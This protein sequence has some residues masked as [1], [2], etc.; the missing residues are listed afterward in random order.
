PLGLSGLFGIPVMAIHRDRARCNAKPAGK[1]AWR[2]VATAVLLSGIA[3]CGAAEPE[4]PPE[5]RSGSVAHPDSSLLVTDPDTGPVGNE[6]APMEFS[7]EI[8]GDPVEFSYVTLAPNVV[9]GTLSGLDKPLLLDAER[10]GAQIVG[11]L[12]EPG[13]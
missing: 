6:T 5:G 2:I 13:E 4:L 7:G 11:E 3:G 10:R 8:D 1:R 12:S 9:R